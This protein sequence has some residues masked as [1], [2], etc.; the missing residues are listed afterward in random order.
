MGTILSAAGIRDSVITYGGNLLDP[1]SLSPYVYSKPNSTLY[2]VTDS[3]HVLGY[4]IVS[5]RTEY[6]Y[7]YTTDS[8]LAKNLVNDKKA[9]PVKERLSRQVRAFLQKAKMQYGGGPFK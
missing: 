9:M 7:Q 2:Q 4:N 1:S 5:N 8:L 3:A 6:L